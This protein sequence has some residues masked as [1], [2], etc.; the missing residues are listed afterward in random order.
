MKSFNF[1]NLQ[2][3]CRLWKFGCY[4]MKVVMAIRGAYYGNIQLFDQTCTV[5]YSRAQRGRL[6]FTFGATFIVSLAITTVAATLL[7]RPKLQRCHRYSKSQYEKDINVAEHPLLLH[8]VTIRFL[9]L[10][11]SFPSDIC[12]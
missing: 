12:R 1:C 10:L 2:V 7:L 6:D 3:R 4:F 11:D 8:V 9:P 5:P